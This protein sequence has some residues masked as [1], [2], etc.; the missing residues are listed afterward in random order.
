[1][2]REP[3]I[4]ELSA[5]TKK[6]FAFP[7][8]DV[9]EN[10]GL[11]EG[12]PVRAGIPGFPQVSEIEVVRHFTRLSQENFCIDTSFYPLGSCTMK[13]NPK[14]N[15]KVAALAHFQAS[16]P[17]APQELVQGNL[18]VLKTL[19]EF[20][21]E[22]T[23][24]DAVTLQPSAGA[25]GE[26]V[27]M[28][29]I[30]AF[31]GDRGD[32][33]KIVL[34]PDSAHG[35]NPSSAHICGYRVQEVKSND[36]GTIDLQALEQV[37]TGD[38]AALMITNPNTLGVFEW[39]IRKICEIV[40]AKGGLVY[41]D[42]ANMNALVGKFRP[43]DMGIDVIHLNL[44]KT[45][46]T[47]HGGG[48]PGC[49][50]VGVKKPLEPFLPVPVVEKG[51]TGLGL[52]FKRPKSIGRVRGFYG[53]FLVMVKALAYIRSLGAAGLKEAAEVAVL[54]SNYIRKSLEGIYHLKYASPTLHE[55]VFSD[56][57]QKEK[58]ILNIDIAKR[59]ID[60]GLH[61]PTMS[62]PLIVPGA[63]MIEPTETESRRDL[64][65]F[66]EAMKAIAR[67][68]V[69]TPDIL[70]S[71]PHQAPVRRLDETKAARNPVLRWEPPKD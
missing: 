6:G 28:M 49:G 18:E 43:G 64:D 1:M 57:L 16:H 71:A 62:F 36:R 8:L 61:P 3:L 33:R 17:Y 9:P 55:C 13:Y 31:L 23:S 37:M 44:H 12:L 2:S 70:H 38:V 15:E 10:K 11:P 20:L 41:M 58:G 56:K 26:L 48:G 30:R 22:I 53:N 32:A 51:E 47:P 52:N 46:S 27:G 50:P 34:I 40:H 66:I 7:K 42:G 5:A 60:Y 65:Q 24:M 63:L 4:F 39:D 59:L 19:E 68:A 14:I 54:N 21:A 29:L 67:E 35:T 25:Q 69:E 45:F